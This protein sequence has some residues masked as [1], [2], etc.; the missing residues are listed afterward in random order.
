[1]D[2]AQSLALEQQLRYMHAD[3]LS[4][5][6][7][8]AAIRKLH[9]GK[10]DGCFD[11]LSSDCFKHAPVILHMHL[12]M[13]FQACLLHGYF[14][15]AVCD[16]Q[17]VPRFK[18]GKINHCDADNYRAISQGSVLFKLF[19]II[20]LFKF[21]NLLN[22]HQNQFGF[23]KGHSTMACV[24]AFK[25]VVL[26]YV[27][28]GSDVFACF[29]DCSKA[30][31]TVNY[32]V[33]FQKLIDCG[34]PRNY[35][36]LLFYCY[37]SQRGYVRW[38]SADS[39]KFQISNGVRQGGILSPIFFNIYIKNLIDKFSTSN[40]GCHFAGMFMGAFAY[41]DDIVIMAPSLFSLRKMMRLCELYAA[42]HFL[43]FNSSKTVCMH[44]P[45]GRRNCTVSQ[46]HVVLCGQTVLFV[47]R[48]CYLGVWVNPLLDDNA[49]FRTL[50]ADFYR[51]FNAC[52]V[53]FCFC[54]RTVL[55]H[56]IVS[57]CTSFYGSVCCMLD[58]AQ[59]TCLSV[60]W[61]KCTRRALGVPYRTHVS[62][63]PAIS[64][65]CL[66]SVQIKSRVLKFAYQC[67]TSGNPAVQCLARF[68]LRSNQHVMGSNVSLI[69]R[70]LNGSVH[71]M[72]RNP[73]LLLH[74]KTTLFHL[75]FPA[76]LTRTAS[77]ILD[78]LESDAPCILTDAEQLEILSYLCCD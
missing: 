19:E 18:S 55:L 26:Y 28:R 38:G 58:T 21:Q 51:K 74:F 49:H 10:V 29:L 16:M 56:L 70:D 35:L 62:L 24:W 61:N 42:G 3:T 77:F 13:L 65:V 46:F 22:T 9:C 20:F 11:G 78:I 4:T 27:F 6:D 71:D 41:A 63:L 47:D 32:A 64:G 7:V 31:D 25:E 8:D 73:S 39:T 12:C 1:M 17:F 60:A 33:L 48:Y 45:A 52:Y 59:F 53:K 75:Q 57:Y 34:I 72:V 67:V 66:A 14:P 15:Q 30:F 54:D 76:P 68:S 69:L 5:Q 37:T 23:K 2:V 43:S 44:F 40:L 50:V 36:R